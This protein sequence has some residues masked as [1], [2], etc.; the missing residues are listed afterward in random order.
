MRVIAGP[1][2]TAWLFALFA[3]LA[4]PA[5]ATPSQ[6]GAAVGEGAA[7]PEA[8]EA[9]QRFRE[10]SVAAEQGQWQAALELYRSAYALY[11]HATTLYNIAYCHGE[12]GEPTRAL[13]Y[14]TRA[15][16]PGAFEA[17]RRLA[18]E[19][20]AAARAFQQVLFERVGSVTLSVDS[21]HPFLLKVDGAPPVPTGTGDGSFV[22]QPDASVASEDRVFLER[23]TLRLDPGSHELVI[24]SE[25]RT[26]R[27]SIEVVPE[28]AVSIPWSLGHETE[29]AGAA[30]TTVAAPPSPAPPSPA[31]T[32]NAET[33]R[34]PAP[35]VADGSSVYY[36]LA[37][38][39]FVVGGAGLGLGL[40]SGIVVLTTDNHLGE[41]CDGSACPEEEAE[42]V[43]RHQTAAQLTN[44]GLWTGL[45]GGVLGVG[46]L[47]LDRTDDRA[48]LSV[49]VEPSRV[50]V[51]GTF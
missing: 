10:A 15:L 1:H 9:R 11:P 22:P 18:P 12:L 14:T 37:I 20:E 16:E 35:V 38:S 41:A 2:S 47:L 44:V 23:V 25:G 17:D 24:V 32:A 48:G 45:A 4:D 42:A 3:A 50:G 26:Y 7:S 39:S 21:K 36:P 19:R 31:P 33:M 28:Q 49:V 30:P 13:Y 27:R 29:P 34:A 40:V 8:S 5:L 43:E 51:R 6:S 46:F